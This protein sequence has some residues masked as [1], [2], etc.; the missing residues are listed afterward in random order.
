MGKLNKRFQRVMLLIVIV[1][2]LYDGAGMCEASLAAQRTAETIEEE[3][4]VSDLKTD[5]LAPETVEKE[6]PTALES[7]I[8]GDGLD[9]FERGAAGKLLNGDTGLAYDAL[10]PVIK[11]IA[12]GERE[13]ATIYV[14]KIDGVEAFADFRGTYEEFDF[15]RLVDAL[16]ADFPYELYWFDKSEGVRST[17]ETHYK[18]MA[19]F[20]ISFYVTENYQDDNP[21]TV[22]SEAAKQTART[23]AVAKEIVEKYAGVSD[24]EKLVG[25]SKEICDLVSYNYE[26]ASDDYDGADKEPWRIRYVF[27]DDKNTNVVCEGYAKAFQYLCDLTTFQS[28]MVK[29]HSVSGY[30]HRSGQGGHMWNIVTMDDGKNYLVDLTNSDS[31]YAGFNDMVFLSGASGNI[32]DGYSLDTRGGE[33]YF[34]FYQDRVE[35]WGAEK[36]SILNIASADYEPGHIHDWNYK[37]DD[38]AD[39]ITVFCDCGRTVVYTLDFNSLKVFNKRPVKVAYSTEDADAKLGALFAPSITYSTE[40]GVLSE[41]GFPYGVGNYTVTLSL[42]ELEV[43]AELVITTPSIISPTIERKTK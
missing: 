18:S 31:D 20:V 17:V 37:A 35:L 7:E 34:T 40:A 26:A 2:L 39:T 28:D 29:C 11:Q 43:S 5:V 42:E 8:P 23:V 1:M 41:E 24:Y 15:E 9:A 32:L 21:Y 13:S 30:V 4:I 36:S 19:L 12:N 27:D 6:Q 16:L 14:G 3:E 22:N 38:T 25:Y 33:R 10:V